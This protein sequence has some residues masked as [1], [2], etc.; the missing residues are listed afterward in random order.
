MLCLTADQPRPSHALDRAPLRPKCRDLDY[1]AAPVW[2]EIF[3]SAGGRLE[4]YPLFISISHALYRNERAR[5]LH[6]IT[7]QMLKSSTGI[8]RIKPSTKRLAFGSD[9][10]WHQLELRE[11]KILNLEFMEHQI[12]KL[13]ISSS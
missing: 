5:R 10:G 11:A 3:E 13:T 7:W 12:R 1:L 8:S 6:K 2:L 9:R 4:K